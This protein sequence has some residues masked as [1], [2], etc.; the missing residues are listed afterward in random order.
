[1]ALSD[2]NKEEF[3]ACPK[4][5]GTNFYEWRF[6]FKAL[7]L[8]NS[9]W[10]AIEGY[11]EDDEDDETPQREKRK[12]ENKCVGLLIRSVSDAY[13]DIIEECETVK[14]AY[15]TLTRECTNYTALH[16]AEFLDEL[17]SVKKTDKITVQEYISQIN[18]H[19]KK[20]KESKQIILPDSA[21]AGLYLRG[22]RHNKKYEA[23]LRSIELGENDFTTTKIRSKLILEELREKSGKEKEEESAVAL[24]V[25][26]KAKGKFQKNNPKKNEETKTEDPK[27]K[28]TKFQ[29]VVF[30]F[31]CGEKGHISRDCPKA[32][33]EDEAETKRKKSEA[34]VVTRPYKALCARKHNQEG[35]G[36][37]LLNIS[38][39]CGGFDLEIQ[40]VLYVP[41]LQDNLMSQGVFQRKGMKIVSYGENTQIY[42]GDEL[43]LKCHLIGTLTFITTANSESIDELRERYVSEE[44]KA[45]FVSTEV[46]H[47][48]LG[49]LHKGALL[50]IQP[51]AEKG[52]I[53]MDEDCEICIKGKMKRSN[54]P[55][56]RESKTIA[57][58]ER[59]HSDVGGPIKPKS[60]GG[61]R[62]FVSFTDDFSNYTTVEVMKKKNEVFKL[63]KK[64]QNRV[65]LQHERKIVE[66]QSDN[67]TEYVNE[68]FKEH[69]ENCGIFHRRTVPGTPSQNGKAER[70]N[71]TLMNSENDTSSE[72]EAQY[73][74]HQERRQEEDEEE[75]V[76]QD[77]SSEEEENEEDEEGSENSDS[78]YEDPLEDL[79][80]IDEAGEVPEE[81]REE[82]REEPRRTVKRDH[83][84]KVVKFKA[85]LVAQGFRQIAAVD[86]EETYSPVMRRRCLRILIAIAVENDWEIHQVDVIAAYLNSPLDVP[87]YMEQPLR[88]EEGGKS[89]IC[90]LKKSL[91]GLKQSGRNWN[92]YLHECLIK[93]GLIQCES[94]PCV[95]YQQDIIVGIH[96][97]D[98]LVVGQ[99]RS[100]RVR[101]RARSEMESHCVPEEIKIKDLGPAS[102]ILSVRVT[103][104]TDRSVKI[105]QNQYVEKVLEEFEAEDLFG[106][107]APLPS[108]ME[109]REHQN[110]ENE[111][112]D[113]KY[114]QAIGCI[115]YAAGGT[116]PDL[117]Y[118]VSRQS[119]YC[120]SPTKQD[121]KNIEH[122]LGYMKTTKRYGI[123]YSKSGNPTEVYVDA[124]YAG[125][126]AD[127]V[128]VSGYIVK[129]ANG[130]ISWRSKKQ[131]LPK[132]SS[133]D[134]EEQPI[135]AASTTHSEY[136]ALYEAT[137]EVEWLIQLLTE[138]GQGDL[139]KKPVKI[140][141]D[142]VGA[143]KVAMRE[144]HSERTKNIHW[145]P[146]LAVH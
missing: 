96:V 98:M 57:I 45:S 3:K 34:K 50:K 84:G 138:L 8:K 104:K 129:L 120:E 94:D 65:E 22:L 125:D 82:R 20:L 87:V 36:R 40:D 145:R 95:Y 53:K 119:Q 100:Q 66:F 128:S 42:D 76:G 108:K 7:C 68:D 133:E 122:I 70:L 47:N 13:H 61:G 126:P 106:H 85:R 107:P 37:V 31:V 4:L 51:I 6:K 78:N 109:R 90:K 74:F 29:R 121:W 59:I 92:G 113:T 28:E 116:R 67:G 60:L 54:F 18:S 49:H 117:A 105:D 19:N 63:F 81:R 93:I 91:Y 5:D 110:E 75:E 112:D 43:F 62:Y 21:I 146:K 25:Q 124:D 103:R 143:M 41:K 39:E 16:I 135:V 139:V 23:F 88:Y 24:K 72:D 30:C 142:N 130:A 127:A 58:L 69:F 118:A 80:E 83:H 140:H 38:A 132:N 141:V 52:N 11:D 137:I 123:H 48:R 115:L 12:I 2:E 89:F 33:E 144:D 79:S 14:G 64:Y 73:T 134:R 99:W 86:F 46:W 111:F 102:L 114:R 9:C 10:E 32:K 131:T 44:K 56:E 35:K 27:K 1:M 136:Y 101:V 26:N 77:P 17:V 55:K 71:L 15:E 97:D